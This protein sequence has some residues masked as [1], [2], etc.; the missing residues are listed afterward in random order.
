MESIQEDLDVYPFSRDDEVACLGTGRFSSIT[1]CRSTLKSIDTDTGFVAVKSF[2]RDTGAL[3]YDRIIQEKLV[4]EL[5]SKN[6]PQNSYITR[7]YSAYKD[8]DRVYL[9]HTAALG[10]SLHKHIGCGLHI[11][12]TRSILTELTSALVHLYNHNCVHRDIKASNIVLNHYGHIILCDFGSSKQ[13]NSAP[14]STGGGNGGGFDFLGNLIESKEE[15]DR[16]FTNQRTYTLTGTIHSMAPEMAFIGYGHSF[17]VDWWAMGVLL[18]EML[19]GKPPAWDHRELSSS[20]SSGSQSIL[21]DSD[22]MV[23]YAKLILLEN[24]QHEERKQESKESE[25]VSDADAGAASRCWNW[26]MISDSSHICYHD[27]ESN[28]LGSKALDLISKLLRID[29]RK[30]FLL[31][32]VEDH[33]FFHGILWREVHSGISRAPFSSVTNTDFDKRL[34]FM[35][36]LDGSSVAGKALG[37]GTGG[38]C[39]G[40]DLTDEQ[41]ALFAGF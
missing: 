9:V 38:V 22:D 32:E 26:N 28:P 1:C 11:N 3:R 39:D 23:R 35:D 6:E 20:S 8:I 5:L 24:T 30:R 17:P 15:I 14:A 36:L 4:L 34:G 40:D 25:N 2:N 33:S 16:S 19:T 29:P 31:K 12:I 13:L 18:H 21:Q 37:L 27:T 7:L 10:G 41:Q